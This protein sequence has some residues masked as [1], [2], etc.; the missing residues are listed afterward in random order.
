MQS[1]SPQCF[2][3]IEVTGPPTDVATT[4][5]SSTHTKSPSPP[6]ILTKATLAPP[7]D[8]YVLPWIHSHHSHPHSRQSSTPQP[9][10]TPPAGLSRRASAVGGSHSNTVNSSSFRKRSVVGGIGLRSRTPSIYQRR[11][12]RRMS[13]MEQLPFVVRWIIGKRLCFRLAFFYS[14]Q[15]RH[16]N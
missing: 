4:T 5:R 3:R 14:F 7:R 16:S 12:S 1:N 10:G 11:G 8:P 15:V 6:V 9:Q 13:T 2:P